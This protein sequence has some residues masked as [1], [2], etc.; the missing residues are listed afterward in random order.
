[1]YAALP[2]F[3]HVSEWPA[4]QTCEENNLGFRNKMEHP[5]QHFGLA[6]LD[7]RYYMSC[8][9]FSCLFPH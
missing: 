5:L 2:E 7:S 3:E 9:T 8:G 1:V 4:A 6:Q